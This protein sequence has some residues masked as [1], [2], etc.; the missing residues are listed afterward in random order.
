MAPRQRIVVSRGPQ[1][2]FFQTAWDEIRASENR[3]I[4]RSIAVFGAGVALLHA[5]FGEFLLP[6]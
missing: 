6:P 2:S 5:G 4:V 3:T 1:K